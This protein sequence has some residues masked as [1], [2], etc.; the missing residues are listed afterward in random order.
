MQPDF[1]SRA[2]TTPLRLPT[3]ARLPA[4]V[5]CEPDADTPGNPN[6]HFSLRR[7]TAAGEMTAAAAG[8][9]LVLLMFAPKPFHDGRE[10]DAGEGDAQNADFGMTSSGARYE[11]GGRPVTYSATARR[12]AGVSGAP[13]RR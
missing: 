1:A 3:N 10:T 4:T 6:A 12:S 9:N 7:G 5:T 2:Y 13:W 8:W 11:P